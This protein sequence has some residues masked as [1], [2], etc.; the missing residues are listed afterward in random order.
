MADL[1]AIAKVRR[2]TAVGWLELLWHATA[3]FA[4]QG[5]IGRCS[6]AWIEAQLDWGGRPGLL[7]EMLTTTRWIDVHSKWRLLVHDWHDHAD[8][9]VRKRLN[10]AGLY[11]LTV[12]EKVTGQDPVTDRKVSATQ[13][14]NGSLPKPEPK[15]EPEPEPSVT[16]KPPSQVPA[17]GGSP[18]GAIAPCDTPKPKGKARPKKAEKSIDQVRQELGI[19]RPWFEEI[20]KVHPAGKEGLKPA[21]EVFKCKVTA[22]EA[23]HELAKEIYRGAVAYAKQCAADPTIRVKWMQGWLNDERW[24]DAGAIPAHKQNQR[25]ETPSERRRRETVAGLGMLRG[26]DD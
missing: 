15:P 9:S 8:D 7:V 26:L 22:D 5:N 16:P 18:N 23:G 10:R 12:S 19:R 6:D 21:M 20:A 1:M 14:E 24:R 2:S 25:E 11:F 3:E 4:P 13:A 17:I